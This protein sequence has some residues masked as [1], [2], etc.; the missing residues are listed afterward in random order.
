MPRRFLLCQFI[1]INIL[2]G[3]TG[4][5]QAPDVLLVLHRCTYGRDIGMSLDVDGTRPGTSLD[6]AVTSEQSSHSA[7]IIA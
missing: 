5:A 1:P 6:E 7:P 2:M 3:N 4:H